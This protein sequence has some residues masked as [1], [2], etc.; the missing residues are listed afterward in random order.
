M[1]IKK[2]IVRFLTAGIFV[3]ATDFGIYY[4]LIHFLSFSL[5]KGIS[6]ICAGIVAATLVAFTI[7]FDMPIGLQTSKYGPF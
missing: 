5:A 4:L 7:N 6:F 3:G 2:E 1:N